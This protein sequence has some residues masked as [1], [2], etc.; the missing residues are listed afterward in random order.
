[1]DTLLWIYLR[2]HKEYI[3]TLFGRNYELFRTNWLMKDTLVNFQ[4][5]YKLNLRDY[6]CD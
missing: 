4:S 2:R 6:A 3:N 5:M 1:M